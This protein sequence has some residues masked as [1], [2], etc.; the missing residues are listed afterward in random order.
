MASIA[1][2]EIQPGRIHVLE[3]EGGRKAIILKSGAEV[4][5]F[6]SICPHMGADLGGGIVCADGSVQ[7]P[8]Q[9]YVFSAAD[10]RFTRNPNEGIMSVLRIPS[11]YYKPEKT[12][13]YRLQPIPF[14][15]R[16]GRLHVGQEAT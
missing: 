6:G 11:A 13:K 14:H 7:C 12:P 3:L 9:G 15:V 10:G 16:D 4:R 2:S 5:V 1:L 8:W